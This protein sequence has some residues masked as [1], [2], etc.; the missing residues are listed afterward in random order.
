M[1]VW[2]NADTP[3]DAARARQLGAE[4]IGLC[5]TEHMFMQQDRLPT[6]QR[7]ILAGD[8][9][10]R[11]EALAK[12]LPFQRDDFA[13]ILEAMQG[14]PV[15]IRLLD[16]PLHEFLP[17]LEELLVEVT[18]LRVTLGSDAP[19][20]KIK[21]AVLHRVLQLHEQNPMLGLRVCRLGIV[22]PEIYAMQVRAIFEAACDLKHRG[23]DARPLVMIPGVGTKEEMQS[24]REAAAAVAGKV[25]AERGIQIDYHIGTMIELPR[26]CVVADE[27]AQFA[28][29]FSFGTNDLTQTTYGYSRDDAEAS[30][31][32]VYLEKRILKNDPFQVLDRRGVGALMRDAVQRGRSVREAIKIGICGEHG[33]EPSSVAFC[34]QLGLDY[35]SCSPYRV[36]IARLAAAQAAI[37]AIE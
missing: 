20:F 5:R 12:L 21:D 32:P 1:E 22:Y 27:L 24:T 11:D 25:L 3:D 9:A 14:L 30:F 8:R 10:S 34:D 23:V 4:G 15:T 16:P 37:G 13:G 35:V 19:D 31:I 28:D 17:S 2:A 29:F 6:V 33:G 18:E 26:A 7:M 36:P